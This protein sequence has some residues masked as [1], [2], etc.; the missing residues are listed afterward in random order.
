M[1]RILHGVGA[2]GVKFVANNKIESNKVLPVEF[3]NMSTGSGVL[4]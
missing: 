1:L 3:T 4:D 2:A